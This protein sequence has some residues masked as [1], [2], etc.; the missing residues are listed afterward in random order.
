M[1]THVAM[2]TPIFSAQRGS[3]ADATGMENGKLRLCRK[4]IRVDASHLAR[5]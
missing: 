3:R 5:L 4:R 2:Q 1:K